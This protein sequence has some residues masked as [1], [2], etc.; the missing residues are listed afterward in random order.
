MN[1]RIFAALAD[2]TRRA[3]FERVAEAPQTVGALASAAAGQPARRLAA[4]EGVK[5]RGTGHR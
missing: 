4:P 2:P 1:N 5:G 3:V